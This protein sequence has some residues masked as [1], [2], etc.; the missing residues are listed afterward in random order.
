MQNHRSEAAQT[1]RDFLRAGGVAALA[2]P[3]VLASATPPP[4]S[5][6][7]DDRAV[8]LLL[9]VGGPSQH[10]TFDPK[11]D[12]PSEVRGPFGSIATAVPGVR[13]GEHLPRLARRL[14]RVTLVRSLH[15]SEAPIH[16]T[17]LQLIQ[18]GSLAGADG[19]PPHVGALAARDLGP[20]GVVPPFAVLPGALRA[21][22]AGLYRGQSAGSLGA[23]FDPFVIGRDGHAEQD[24][25][26]LDLNRESASTRDAYG[27]TTFGRDC[28]RARRLVE[29]G[30]RLVV[31]NMYESVF[32]GPSWDCHGSSP[33][34]SLNDYRST[35]LPTFDRAFCALIDDL[36]ARGRLGSTLVVA[37]GEFG[38][39]PRV[40]ASGGRD[41]WPSVW[42]A[43]V[44]GGGTPGGAVVGA[45][46]RLGA[47]PDRD[48]IH[49]SHIA[50]AM[51]ASL[52]G[53]PVA[54]PLS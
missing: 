32:H 36:D 6:A 53:K 7:A 31:V 9:L 23:G 12:A 16:E 2:G 34:S 33:F 10:E 37:T 29:A 30:S 47:E 1:R 25:A 41:H 26:A 28:L 22:G 20:R 11:P 24:R 35:V 3:S 21:T 51:L 14:D 46:D 13:L 39:T 8:I 17:G 49:A 40:N 44:A 15:H 19:E 27:A 18:T 52:E 43:V 54:W 38:R 4:R 42:S 45:S 5:R 50:N 48:P